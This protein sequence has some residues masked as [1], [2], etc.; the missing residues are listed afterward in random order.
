MLKKNKILLVGKEFEQ[1]M[2]FLFGKIVTVKKQAMAL[3][4]QKKQKKF[5]KVREK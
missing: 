5:N 1:I 2:F 3:K 4:T